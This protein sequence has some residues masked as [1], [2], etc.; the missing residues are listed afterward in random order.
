MQLQGRPR[1]EAWLRLCLRKKTTRHGSLRASLIPCRLRR[2]VLLALDP[3]E[4]R[5]PRD[6]S[7][8]FLPAIRASS[9][10]N[11]CAVPFWWAAR[12]PLAAIARCAWGSIAA[13]PRGVLRLTPPR[14]STPPSL[15]L[16]PIEPFPPFSELL[17][18]KPTPA[19]LL[20]PLRSSI[21]SPGLVASSAI[22]HLLPRFYEFERREHPTSIV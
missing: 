13:N 9:L 20:R 7:P 10:V 12:P 14:A 17:F 19:P 8:P 5:P 21:L 11:S 2:Q 4:R 22:I 6:A 15:R 18:P 16:P 3:V 1:W